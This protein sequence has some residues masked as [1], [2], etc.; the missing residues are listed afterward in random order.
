VARPRV[1]A[2]ASFTLTKPGLD[3]VVAV[4]SSLSRK[5][6]SPLVQVWDR[7]AY[8]G[9]SSP[10]NSSRHRVEVLM[11]RIGFLRGRTRA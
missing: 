1:T 6:T 7:M 2:Q 8:L 3:A 9:V 5:V 4:G 11:S 10:K